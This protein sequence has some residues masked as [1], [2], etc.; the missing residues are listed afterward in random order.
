MSLIA[1][2]VSAVLLAL[3][4]MYIGEAVDYIIG[5]GQVNFDMILK[6]IIKQTIHWFPEAEKLDMMLGIVDKLLRQ[7]PVF[8]LENRPEPEAARLSY[9]TMRRAAE[10]L[11]L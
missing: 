10:E 5:V 7:I 9:E 4:P 3:I 6:R 1:Y 8:E 11:G 2:L